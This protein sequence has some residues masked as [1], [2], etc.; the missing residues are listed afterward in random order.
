MLAALPREKGNP[1]VIRGKV[2]E[3]SEPARDWRG[4]GDIDPHPKQDDLTTLT[5]HGLL[6]SCS[7]ALYIPSV[8]AER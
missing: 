2:P 5:A 6:A 4:Q 8:I 7:W 3:R 1:W